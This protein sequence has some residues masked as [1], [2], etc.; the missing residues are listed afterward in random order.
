MKLKAGFCR[1]DCTRA[2]AEEIHAEAQKIIF[3]IALSG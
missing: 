3:A 1:Q 2:K